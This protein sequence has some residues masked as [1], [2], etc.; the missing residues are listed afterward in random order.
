MSQT[1]LTR[2]ETPSVLRT[3]A[4]LDRARR[5]L[6]D[7][8]VRYARRRRRVGIAGYV[9]GAMLVILFSLLFFAPKR[10]ELFGHEPW[11]YMTV[12]LT[13]ILAMSANGLVVGDL[14][15]AVNGLVTQRRDLDVAPVMEIAELAQ[16]LDVP[17]VKARMQEIAASGR[18]LTHADCRALQHEGASWHA[19]RDAEKA[20]DKVRSETGLRRQS[21]V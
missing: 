13:V 20:F 1:E 21:T 15:H 2:D 18:E 10:W 7:K 16:Y 5:D 9:L 6:D 14:N 3:Q 19:L 17:A 12:T 11:A 8:I 4:D